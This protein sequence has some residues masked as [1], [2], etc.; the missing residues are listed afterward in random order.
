MA[1]REQNINTAIDTLTAEL[2]GLTC[3]KDMDRAKKVADLIDQLR[4][5]AAEKSA[6]FEIEV[7]GV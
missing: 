2:A 4:K 7:R 3:T 1:T 6:P 5:A